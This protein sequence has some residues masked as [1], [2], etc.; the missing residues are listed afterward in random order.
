MK[1]K[2]SLKRNEEIAKIVRKKVLEK[3]NCYVIYYYPKQ[4]V[5]HTRICISVSKKLGKAVI[6]N[7]IKRQVREMIT[8]IFD[9]NLS[10]D[11]VIVVRRDYP[12]IDFEH[13]KNKLEK[14]Y[15]R[16]TSKIKG[17]I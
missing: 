1:K 2:Y 8:S 10:Y 9:F 12:E 11:F 5:N 15:L 6:R 16:I 13:N 7:K 3:N 14:L 17:D 4:N